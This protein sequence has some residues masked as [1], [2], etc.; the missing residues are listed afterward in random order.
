M[1]LYPLKYGNLS[2]FLLVVVRVVK[3]KVKSFQPEVWTRGAPRLLVL[4]YFKIKPSIGRTLPVPIKAEAANKVA[5]PAI[6][7]TP[8]TEKQGE[9]G[10]R[11]L[12]R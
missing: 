9:G 6:T 3:D 12:G 11:K 7:P 2:A 5:P 8:L 10:L 1:N 4:S